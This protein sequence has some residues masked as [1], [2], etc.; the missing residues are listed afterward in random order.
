[1][2]VYSFEKISEPYGAGLLIVAANSEEEAIALANV[3]EKISNWYG[4]ID[5]CNLIPELEAKVD[6]P[7]IIKKCFYAE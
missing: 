2:N 4:F 5:E 3:K 6:V 7:Q 1:M